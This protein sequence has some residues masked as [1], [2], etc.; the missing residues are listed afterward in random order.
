MKANRSL[1]FLARGIGVFACLGS[2]IIAAQSTPAPCSLLTTAQ[3]S[4]A[5]GVTV[6]AAQPIATTGCS[7]TAPPVTATLSLWNA[8]NWEKFKSPLTGMIRTAV[9]GLG[10]DAFFSTAGSVPK[11]FTTLTVKKGTTAYV[12]RIYGIDEPA[13]RAAEKTLAANVLAKL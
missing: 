10:E 13:Q 7:W 5:V 12:F 11:Q 1:R 2:Q 3:V 9:A 6:G 8:S 4:A